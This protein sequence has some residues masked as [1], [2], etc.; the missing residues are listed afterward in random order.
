MKLRLTIWFFALQLYFI[1]CSSVTALASTP[2]VTTD[3]DRIVVMISVDGLANFYMD[4]PKAP[5]PTIRQLAA[6]GAQAASMKASDPT[7]TWPN[8]T[9]LVTGVSPARHGVVGNNWYDRAKGEKV[10]LI[11]DPVLDKDQ[12]VKV[13]TIY[14]LAK[15]AGLRTAAIKWPATRNAHSLDWTAPDVGR[16]ELVRKYTTPALLKECKA[17]GYDIVYGDEGKHVSRRR[18][19]EEDD[20]WTQVF[21]MI[22]HKHRPN[23][24]LLHLIAVDHTQHIDGPRSQGAYEAIKA[25][26]RDVHEVWEELQRDFPGKATLIIVSDHGFS[27]NTTKINPFAILEKAGVIEMKGR[28]I[29]GGSVYPLIQGGSVLV[30]VLDEGHRN[31]ILR[32]VKQAFAHVDG[33][34]KVLGP[35][36]FAD[37]GIGD[38]KLDPHAPDMVVFGKVGYYFGDTAAGGKKEHKGSHGQD[39]HLPDLHPMFVA[40]GQRIKPGTKLG[41]IDNR[42]VAPTIAKLLGVEIPNAEGRP[43]TEALSQ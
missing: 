22:L 21:N 38:P 33:I 17:A 7:V 13:P 9:T 41:D 43:L 30:Y 35:E 25:C 1:G 5:M 2:T 37:Y 16:E 36:G 4:D 12:I 34:Y 19:I 42:S 29:A 6:E 20:L 3:R 39:S 31:A 18:T 27:P 28:R 23:L 11:W 32:K 15:K 14:D 10:T 8:H 40:W 24:A 26:D